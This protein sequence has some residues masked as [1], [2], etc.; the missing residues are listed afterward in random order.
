VAEANAAAE[1]RADEL[2][3]LNERLRTMDE[4]RS[5]SCAW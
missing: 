4:Q 3:A 2:A 1:P 5:C